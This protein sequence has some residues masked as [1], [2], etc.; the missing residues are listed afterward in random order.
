MRREDIFMD[1]IGELNDNYIALAMSR[2]KRRAIV[3]ETRN[4]TFVQPVEVENNVSKRELRLYYITRVLGMAAVTFLIV[5]AAVLLIMNWDKIVVRD[6]DTPPVVT[7]DITTVTDPSIIDQTETGYIDAADWGITMEAVSADTDG[8]IIEIRQS[9]GS[10]TGQIKYGYGFTVEKYTNGEWVQEISQYGDYWE[11]E[12]APDG[13]NREYWTYGKKLDAGKYRI[14]KN[15]VDLRAP[16]DFDIA[17]GYAEFEISGT[18]DIDRFE[19][20]TDKSM[21]EPGISSMYGSYLDFSSPWKIKVSHILL[22]MY[23]EQRERGSEWVKNK[24]NIPTPYNLYDSMNL[25]SFC[26]DLDISWESIEE[27]VREWDGSVRYPAGTPKEEYEDIERFT[28]E[29]LTALRNG[30][31][32]TIVK[33]LASDH[34]VVVGENVFSPEWLYYHTIEDYKAVG[35]TPEMIAEKL[36]LYEDTFIGKDIGTDMADES[37]T[38]FK[39]KLESYIISGKTIPDDMLGEWSVADVTDNAFSEQEFGSDNLE[40]LNKMLDSLGNNDVKKLYKQAYALCTLTERDYDDLSNDNLLKQIYGDFQYSSERAVLLDISGR[41]YACSSGYLWESFV[42]A[43]KS[44]FEEDYADRLIADMP[45][46]Y[47]YGKELYYSGVTSTLRVMLYPEYTVLKNTNDEIVIREICY[48]IDYETKEVTD[49]VRYVN[50][51]R[52]VKTS[53][54]W[55]CAYFGINDTKKSSDQITDT[56]AREYTLNRIDDPFGDHAFEILENAFYG[57]WEIAEKHEPYEEKLSLTYSKDAFYHGMIVVSG[58]CET[59]EIYAIMFSNGGAGGALVIEK[60]NPDVMYWTDAYP[61]SADGYTISVGDNIPGT[62]INRK[63]EVPGLKSGE[64]SELGK[65]KLFNIYGKK[66]EDSF[67]ELLEKDKSEGI[68]FDGR[69]VYPTWKDIFRFGEATPYLGTLTDDEVRIFMPYYYEDDSGNATELYAEMWF[70]KYYN[71]DWGSG[72]NVSITPDASG[73]KI[74]G[75]P[76]TNNELEEFDLDA[77]TGIVFSADNKT[78]KELNNFLESIDNKEI[79]QQYKRAYVLRTVAFAS[80]DV[81]ATLVD[82]TGKVVAVSTGFTFESVMNAYLQVFNSEYVSDLFADLHFYRYGDE[83]FCAGV[84]V[85]TPDCITEY[86]FNSPDDS[87]DLAVFA[88]MGYAKDEKTGKKTDEIVLSKD[89]IFELSSVGWRCRHFGISDRTQ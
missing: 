80:D 81:A 16:G 70:S 35:V 61:I 50:E 54:G 85:S 17:S 2:P 34:S 74:N 38:L 58:I 7:T 3:S 63:A 87:P 86:V 78:I 9:G 37:W 18:N 62:Y 55:R 15:F 10:F 33:L 46:V 52:F 56:S 32:K 60:S 45:C 11:Y 12:L 13:T 14:V 19:Q 22:G 64:L 44:V 41:A 25:V 82:D 28:E 89:A 84:S 71:G 65:K 73:L 59:D 49:E 23:T 26:R 67:N 47:H 48:N 43:Y 31:D 20:I 88:V 30:D 6:P 75:K 1:L 69:T 79:V 53:D 77:M 40:S 5:G 68:Y 66:F 83:L 21:P 29:E 8:V 24:E 4:I 42:S 39:A 27:N 57:E 51:N 36:P 76:I 72:T